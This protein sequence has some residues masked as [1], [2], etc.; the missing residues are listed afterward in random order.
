[1]TAVDAYFG[2]FRRHAHIIFH[3]RLPNPWVRHFTG[4]MLTGLIALAAITLTGH[5]LALVL[6]TG[7]EAIN[8]A[9]AG[10]LTLQVALI[11][12]IAKLYA[13]LA[14]VGAGGS[15]GLLLPSLY[16]GAMT[17]VIIAHFFDYPSMTLVIPAITASLVAVVNVPLTAILF[18]LEIFGA[19]YLLPALVTL[20]ITLIFAHDNSIY[21]TQREYDVSRQIIPGYSVR[22]I[23]VPPAWAGHTLIELALRARYD[24]NVLGMAETTR[25]GTRIHPNVPVTKPLKVH[26]LLIVLGKDEKLEELEQAVRMTSMQ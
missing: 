3:A 24:V 8:Q 18:T 6:G 26:D 14:T 19:N 12:L 4:A 10:H 25:N 23:A 17:G 15:A 16:L 5:S 13:T 21:R 22:R 9:L 20:V 11:A 2:S 7:E 1:V